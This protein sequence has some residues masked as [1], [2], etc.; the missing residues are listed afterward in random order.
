MA[1]EKEVKARISHKIDTEENWNKATGFIPK[2]GEWIFYDIDSTHTELRFKIGDGTTSIINL[3]FQ[4]NSIS[5][6]DIDE[7][8]GAIIY[9]ADEVEL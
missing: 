5:D 1:I 9:M 6:S 4:I 2:R 7:I 8:C 3:P